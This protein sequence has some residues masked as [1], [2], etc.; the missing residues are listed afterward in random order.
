MGLKTLK[1]HAIQHLTND[2]LNFGVPME[3]DTGSNETGHK[4]EKTAAKLTQKKKKILICKPHGVFW[5]CC[6]IWLR[7]KSMACACG[8]ITKTSKKVRCQSQNKTKTKFVA[9]PIV[10]NLMKNDKQKHWQIKNKKRAK[11]KQC[12]WRMTFLNFV[13]GITRNCQQ[14]HAKNCSSIKLASQWMCFSRKFQL[15]KERLA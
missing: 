2:I 7:P 6:W 14:L 4:P 3:S 8:I 1:F 11:N 13:A 15:F 12:Q 5:K 10:W 9:P